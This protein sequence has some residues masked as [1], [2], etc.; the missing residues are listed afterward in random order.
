MLDDMADILYKFPR[1]SVPGEL[2]EKISY[3]DREGK[4][5]QISRR[6]VPSFI[7]QPGMIARNFRPWLIRGAA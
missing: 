5:R 4:V 6:T 3:E 2:E 1:N 7:E